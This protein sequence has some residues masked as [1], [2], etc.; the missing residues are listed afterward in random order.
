MAADVRS[1]R[2]AANKAAAAGK[3]KKAVEHYLELERAE[4]KDAAWPKRTAE[5]YRRLGKDQEGIEAY[6]R[7]VARY[8]EAGFLAQ[9]IA[10]CKMILQLDPTHSRAAAAM[11]DMNEKLRGHTSSRMTKAMPLIELNL[12]GDAPASAGVTGPPAT[13]PESAPKPPAPPPAAPPASRL[14][15]DSLF[16]VKLAATDAPEIEIDDVVE[17]DDDDAVEVVD[18]EG[19]ELLIA[20]G[21]DDG[22]NS[23]EFAIEPA[24]GSD[25]DIQP[26][27]LFSSFQDRGRSGPS[28]PPPDSGVPL[29][30][31]KLAQGAYGS[32]KPAA[33]GGEAAPA[34]P[35]SPAPEVLNLYVQ[36]VPD[37]A[38]EDPD[39]G[40]SP[41]AQDALLGMTM[42]TL[43]RV[44]AFEHVPVEQMR[45]L[46]DSI[47][48]INLPEGET[49][50]LSAQNGRLFVISDGSVEIAEG[51]LGLDHRGAGDYFGEAGA[52]MGC[53]DD[54]VALALADCE[55][56][57]IER[58]AFHALLSENAEIAQRL[59]DETRQRRT[60][61]LLAHHELFAP[62]NS[63]DKESLL[64]KFEFRRLAPGDV[65]VE[66]GEPSKAL[67]VLL[68]G[69]VQILAK[70][71][72]VGTLGPGEILGESGMLPGE[73]SPATEVV[74]SRAWALEL[75]DRSFRVLMMTHP[76]VLEVV[77]NV[78]ERRRRLLP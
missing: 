46:I 67:L 51:A 65:V 47:E 30:V 76:H 12:D 5:M 24:E 49:I 36:E 3:F 42:D 21:D 72:L 48:L 66:E 26:T 78:M 29:S 1:L 63:D 56:I 23:L 31:F 77:G 62:F 20:A 64:A 59:V 19:V 7:C 43:R 25:L 16:E 14:A 71:D 75:S 8:A 27:N 13:A 61:R 41:T 18:D 4:P 53:A 22:G 60:A 73:I 6:E 52:L 34:R 68:T 2:D 55:F 17:L 33:F 40:T 54:A 44:P 50:D 39:T 10:V 35:A 58:D 9:A 32:P 37:E 45:Q 15:R 69:H 74:L 70:G 38:F 57:A 11:A 28:I